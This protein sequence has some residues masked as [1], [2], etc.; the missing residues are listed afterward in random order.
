MALLCIEI[1]DIFNKLVYYNRGNMIELNKDF[2]AYPELAGQEVYWLTAD[3]H[4]LYCAHLERSESKNAIKQTQLLYEK[5]TYKMNS[6]GFRCEEFTGE[7]GDSI[8]FLGCSHTV[9]IGLPYTHTFANIVATELGLQNYN[10]GQGGSSND[11]AYRF[12]SYWL[13][14]LMPKVVVLLS[15]EANRSEL[16]TTA[17]VYQLGAHASVKRLREYMQA[18]FNSPLNAVLNKEKNQLAIR[19]LCNNLSIPF[20]LLDEHDLGNMDY[21]RDLMH[22]GTITNK[23][24]A[25]KIL[26][27]VRAAIKET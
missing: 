14:R 6:Q 11:T 19:Q 20:V 22:S 8:V 21:A 9:G 27:K 15:P 10:L 23:H 1:I 3:T 12:S 26:P 5:F 25:E 2:S 7:P 18:Y 13:H 4:E 24:F 17:Q 16:I